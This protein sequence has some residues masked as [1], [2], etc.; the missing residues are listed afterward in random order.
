[1]I[2]V[3]RDKAPKGFFKNQKK[4]KNNRARKSSQCFQVEASQQSIEKDVR[5][6]CLITE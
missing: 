5:D 4:D 3:K 1:M 2:V 6:I